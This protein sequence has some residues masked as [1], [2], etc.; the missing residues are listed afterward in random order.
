MTDWVATAG[1]PSLIYLSYP[2]DSDDGVSYI[3]MKSFPHF[4][5]WTTAQR[6]LN[7]NQR[8]NEFGNLSKICMQMNRVDHV[9]PVKSTAVTRFACKT[10]FRVVRK[11][12]KLVK[13]KFC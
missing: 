3:L 5:H 7:S 8:P 13:A 9:V 2:N 6:L 12:V 1:W 4:S 10:W 11:R